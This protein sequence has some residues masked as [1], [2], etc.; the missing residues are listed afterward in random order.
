M[1]LEPCGLWHLTPRCWQQ[2]FYSSKLQDV[3]SLDQAD[4]Y[5]TPHT[6]SMHYTEICGTIFTFPQG[7]LSH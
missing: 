4:L 1:P 2:I 7:V 5:S 3:T 6:C